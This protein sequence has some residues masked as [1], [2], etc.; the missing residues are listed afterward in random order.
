LIMRNSFVADLLS[1]HS[2]CVGT[3]IKE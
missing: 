1:E 3:V 2:P